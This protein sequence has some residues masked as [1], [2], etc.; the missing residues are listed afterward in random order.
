MTPRYSSDRPNKPPAPDLLGR[1]AFAARLAEDLKAW[2][3]NDS[4]VIALYG[5]WGCGKTSLKERVLFHLRAADSEYPILD[6][7][8][9]ELS[10][11]GNLSLSLLRELDSI[12][13]TG[14]AGEK[15][16]KAS[17][18][19][20]KY[21]ARLIF[22][23]TA[24]K[25]A[26][27][28][29]VLQH[30]LAG[31]AAGIFGEG[32][33]RLGRVLRLGGE[34]KKAGVESATTSDIK[35]GLA[36]AME[37]LDRAI[38]V[39][40]DDIDRLNQGEIREIFQL[41]KIN[42][43]FPQLIYLLLFDRSVVSEALNAISGNRGKEYLEKIVQ[44]PY[45]IPEAPRDKIQE[46]LFK[47]IDECLE[48]SGALSRWEKERWSTLYLDGMRAYFQNLRHVYRF[49]GSFDF[50]VRH[51]KR[52]GGFEVNP[53]DLLGLETLRVFE[54][55]LYERLF[56]EKSLLT[57]D[58]GRHIFSEKKTE[59]IVADSKELISIV[60]ESTRPFARHIIHTVFPPTLG[61][62]IGHGS[63][64]EWLRQG[65]V[66][67][68]EIFDKY[69]TLQLAPSEIGQIELES[70]VN[71]AGDRDKFATILKDFEKRD[72]IDKVMDR[73]EAYKDH[74]PLSSMPALITALC[75]CADSFPERVPGFFDF[76]SLLHAYRVSYFGLRREPDA[77]TRFRILKDAVKES[78][79]VVLPVTIT[80]REER[81][82]D[83]DRTPS[84]YLV[85]E[86]D[87]GELK[88]LCVQKLRSA[89]ANGTLKTVTHGAM[90]LWRW[91]E[92]DSLDEV[93]T[94]VT[95]E[96]INDNGTAWLLATLT[97]TA[98]T[99]GRPFH[100]LTFSTLDRFIDPAVVKDRAEKVEP[101]SLTKKQQIG[102]E[103]FWRAWRRKQAGKPD[104]T[105]HEW[106]SEGDD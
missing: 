44:V 26:A 1:D 102:L 72:L 17:K 100:Y 18:W 81:R 61:A 60:T 70:L 37:E 73:L 85:N 20:E 87:V 84:D 78:K 59:E 12:L 106:G 6:F 46:V 30:P 28:A 57:G 103:Q 64:D 21:A 47:G 98:T 94:W 32:L 99:N 35:V 63:T 76:D 97:S 16:E 41:V 22:A 34:V 38:L 25:T 23:G 4:L 67:R 50:Q 88:A 91:S 27:P 48:R 101:A 52:E 71:A 33:T 74:L 66:C 89:A 92:W 15:S 68:S 75:D 86:S 80:S 53:V 8:P 105:G 54:P 40:V 55:A 79:G 69:F 56:P 90:L 14:K 49:L 29:L 10:G 83:S 104:L 58:Y 51:F 93:R 11:A 77:Q 3:G 95:N 31:G 36:T 42:A 7:N 65:R 13:K 2:R 19:L 62:G 43:D 24:V 82:K 96:C 39:V 45:H 9:W 5:S